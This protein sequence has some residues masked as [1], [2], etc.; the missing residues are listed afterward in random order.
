MGRY[1]IFGRGTQTALARSH[2]HA[3]LA[4]GVLLGA[5]VSGALAVVSMSS[6]AVAAATC[7]AGGGMHVGSGCSANGTGSVAVGL[8][9]DTTATADGTHDSALA[10]GT[11]ADAEATNGN[12]NTALTLGNSSTAQAGLDQGTGTKPESVD[13]RSLVIGV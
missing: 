2:D 8:G 13:G 4:G 7:M 1:G 5:L 12:N 11:K 6:P 9:P 10:I 3:Q